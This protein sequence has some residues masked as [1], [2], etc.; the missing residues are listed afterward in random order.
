VSARDKLLEMIL[1]DPCCDFR[2]DGEVLAEKEAQEA[3]DAFARYVRSATLREG[4]DAIDRDLPE[5][6]KET[7]GFWAEI[8][9]V[10]TAQQ[11]A[12]LLRCLAKE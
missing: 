10:S 8:R 6:V 3:I 9:T 4:A 12:E 11:A 2:T 7:V 1:S 5:T